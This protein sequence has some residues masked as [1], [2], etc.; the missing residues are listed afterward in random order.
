[1]AP[2]K[3]QTGK[4]KELRQEVKEYFLKKRGR[5]ITGIPAISGRHSDE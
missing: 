3:R 5:R 1:M 4:K 2:Q